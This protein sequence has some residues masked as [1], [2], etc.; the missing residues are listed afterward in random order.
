M[1]RR[2]ASIGKCVITDKPSTSVMSRIN[3]SDEQVCI[4]KK[5]YQTCPTYENHSLP[6][7]ISVGE[8]ILK[9]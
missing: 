6:Y 2:Y 5:K 9:A 1:Q 7:Y 3:H 8:G 4:M